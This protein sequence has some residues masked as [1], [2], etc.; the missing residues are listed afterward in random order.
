MSPL[1]VLN[2][3][4]SSYHSSACG[5][6][7]LTS[8]DTAARDWSRHVTVI[9]S[10]VWVC[11][12]LCACSRICVSLW[13]SVV[14]TPAP[15]ICSK[16]EHCHLAVNPCVKMCVCLCMS[17]NGCTPMW[18]SLCHC[19]NY[20]YPQF[21]GHFILPSLWISKKYLHP[22]KDFY[23]ISRNGWPEWPQMARLVSRAWLI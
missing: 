19:V 7:W 13:W 5:V 23:G 20:I 18:D 15:D 2:A 10:Q 12:S 3:L 21:L 4:C 11:V 22:C 14:L 17:E 1:V 6:N 8:L 9:A 16:T